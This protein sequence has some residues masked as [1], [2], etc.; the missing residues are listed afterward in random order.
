MNKNM[1]N[2]N[3]NHEQIMEEELDLEYV[4][5]KPEKPKRDYLLPASILISVFVLSGILIYTTGLRTENGKTGIKTQHSDAQKTEAP[6]EVITTSQV[7]LPATW[8]DLGKKMAAAGVIDETQFKALY[9]QRGGL[10]QGEQAL[11]DSSDNKNLVINQ[12]NAGTLLN[13]LWA[14]GLGNK[15]PILENGPMQDKKYGGAGNFASTG[16]W[17]IAAGKPM[18]HYSAHKFITLTADQ[19]ALVER[20]AKGIYRPCCGNSVYFPDC[21]HGMAMLGLLELMASQGVNEAQMYK[22][23]LSVNSFWFPDMYRTIARYFESK[24]ISPQSVD[25]KEILGTAYSSGQGFARIQSLVPAEKPTQSQG[26]CGVD[27]GQPSQPQQQQSG[28]GV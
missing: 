26:G 12:Q 16:G 13:I 20:V 5:L 27:A 4:E 25:P 6:R 1:K 19:Q 15:N 28:C 10:S 11:L 22:A 2:E 17:T 14:L 8:G 23:A 9:A 3:N 18:D 21:N 24:G 7:V